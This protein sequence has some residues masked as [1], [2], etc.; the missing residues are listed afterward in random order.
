MLKSFETILEALNE[1]GTLATGE[2]LKQ[3][4]TDGSDRKIKNEKWTS[5]FDPF[6]AYQTPYGE[7]Q[8]ARHVYQ[9]SKGCKTYCPLENTARIIVTSTPRFAFINSN[10]FAK[11]ASFLKMT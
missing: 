7:V 1:T 5:K 8:V 10:K 4:D 2:A 3:F 11:M 6:K 9:N